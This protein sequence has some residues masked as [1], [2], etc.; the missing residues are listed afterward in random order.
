[1]AN[2]EVRV[3]C[4]SVPGRVAAKASGGVSERPPIKG[5]NDVAMDWLDRW[6]KYCKPE[7]RVDLWFAQGRVFY[8]SYRVPLKNVRCLS[9]ISVSTQSIPVT[10]TLKRT[11]ASRRL[12]CCTAFHAK[13][14]QSVARTTCSYGS[15]NGPRVHSLG[16]P[17]T[18]TASRRGITEGCVRKSLNRLLLIWN[19]V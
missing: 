14:R 8:S 12:V 17:I 1:V 11:A 18:K 6:Y 10:S 13:M 5:C 16:P 2:A 3:L 19:R 7:V 4:E 9:D 15:S